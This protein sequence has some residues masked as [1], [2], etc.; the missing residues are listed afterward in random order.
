MAWTSIKKWL[1]QDNLTA[2][3]LNSYLRDN[4]METLAAPTQADFGI[5]TT[6]GTNQVKWSR[7]RVA[8]KTTTSTTTSTTPVAVGPTMSAISHSGAFL[9]T[10]V[11]Q[12]QNS[13]TGTTFY[14]PGP[15]PA[16]GSVATTYAASVQGTSVVTVT[17]HTLWWPA[18][19]VTDLTGYLWTTSGTASVFR[20]YYTFL[21]L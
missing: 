6:S 3:E 7:V 16:T 14:M 21:P 8:N 13:T 1:P 11:A 12:L 5:G 18:S 19:G 20:A 2:A 17:G 10:F 9:V 15:N 4:L